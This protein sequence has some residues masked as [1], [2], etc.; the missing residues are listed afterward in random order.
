VHPIN[1]QQR[2]RDYF[3]HKFMAHLKNN[4]QNNVN[5]QDS[6]E[7]TLTSI[8]SIKRLQIANDL[9]AGN[10]HTIDKLKHKLE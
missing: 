3:K 7:N 8:A 5:S 1:R 6:Q 4:Y 10:V 9:G 2:L